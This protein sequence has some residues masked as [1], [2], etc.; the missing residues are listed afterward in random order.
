MPSVRG[1]RALLSR[2]NPNRSTGVAGILGFG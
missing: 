2:V 1:L